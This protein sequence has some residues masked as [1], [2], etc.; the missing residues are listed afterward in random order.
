M[1]ESPL[2]LVAVYATVGLL[3]LRRFPYADRR[4]WAREVVVAP[5]VVQRRWSSSI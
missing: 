1:K 5:S 2:P 3:Q 4:I